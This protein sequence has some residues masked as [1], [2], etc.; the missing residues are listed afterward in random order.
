MPG[1]WNDLQRGSRPMGFAARHCFLFTDSRKQLS[2]YLF[3][4]ADRDTAWIALSA[5]RLNPASA[6]LPRQKEH[7]HEFVKENFADLIGK[8][9]IAEVVEAGVPYNKIVAKAE[10]EG[11][12]HGDQR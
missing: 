4:G 3:R 2:E 11:Q 12:R 5:T 8:V 1:R 7:L 6:F 10:E 9:E